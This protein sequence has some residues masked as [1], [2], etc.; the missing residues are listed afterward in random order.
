MVESNTDLREC[1]TKNWSV[2]NLLTEIQQL[3][4]LGSW[5]WDVVSNKVTWSDE[6][7]RIYNLDPQTFPPTFEGYLPQANPGDRPRAQG[8]VDQPFGECP[9]FDPED[10]IAPG[11][12]E[13]R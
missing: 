2:E 6:L 8:R 12:G 9:P 7:Y 11:A 10:R 4:T 3:A 13:W 5:E 1:P